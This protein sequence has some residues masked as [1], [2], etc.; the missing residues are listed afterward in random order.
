MVEIFG[1][2]HTD[3]R[4]GRRL[5]VRRVLARLSRAAGDGRA[6]GGEGARRIA[7][8]FDPP[9]PPAAGRPRV[10]LSYA[11]SL[12]GCI[13]AEPGRP[14]ALSGRPSLALTHGL[15]ARHDA[16]LVGIGTV[17][18]DDPRLNVRL[19]E[20]PDPRPVVL[21]TGLRFPEGARMLA[22]AGPRP[23]I[24]AGAGADPGRARRL[25]ALGARVV[26]VRRG[27]G[28]VDLPAAL[29][30]LAELGVRRLMVEGGARVITAFL[31]GRLVDR[32]VVTVAPVLVG[33]LKAVDRFCPPDPACLPRLRNVRYERVGEDMVVC[34]DLECEAA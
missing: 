8:L 12:D 28:G 7:A 29:A 31:C 14:L 30:R 34:G 23:W 19:A 11:Q 2:G 26:R 33:G 15:R 17:L 24:V 9:P 4:E 20:G 18:A 1:P 21:D 13:A 10:T 27:P 6:G 5:S 3:R 25:E 32:V 22:N 16:I